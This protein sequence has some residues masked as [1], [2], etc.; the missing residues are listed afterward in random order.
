MY[1]Y[2]SAHTYT[3][4][5]MHAHLYI[6]IYI[7]MYLSNY[8]KYIY[9]YT[10]IYI[11]VYV[12]IYIYIYICIYLFIYLCTY[13]CMYVCVYVC[14]CVCVLAASSSPLGLL[15]SSPCTLKRSA[16]KA[17]AKPERE[18]QNSDRVAPMCVFCP[19]AFWRGVFEYLLV[20]GSRGGTKGRLRGRKAVETNTNSICSFLSP[21]TP[22][23]PSPAPRGDTRCS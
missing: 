19:D 23:R 16:G 12:Y 18:R 8:I 5:C 10:Y 14:M 3:H 21:Q 9:I 1:V 4:T 20:L 17:H 11:S 15:S 13:T 22:S 2:V 6:Y 7:Y